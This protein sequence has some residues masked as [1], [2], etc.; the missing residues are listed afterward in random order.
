MRRQRLTARTGEKGILAEI[1]KL[2]RLAEG[3]DS[4][5]EQEAQA[6]ADEEVDIAEES[7]GVSVEEDVGDQNEKANE[8]WPMSA[9]QR[10]ALAKRLVAIAKSLAQ[11]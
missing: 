3:M 5:L 1:A 7:T 6:L 4:E 9:S 8:N 2:E 11:G 10:H